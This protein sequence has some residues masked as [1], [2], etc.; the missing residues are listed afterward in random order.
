MTSTQTPTSIVVGAGVAGLTA[1]YRL[2]Q[3]GFRVTVLEAKHLPGGR[4]ADEMRGSFYAYTGA[5]GLFAFYRDMWSLLDELGIKDKLVSYPTMGQGIADNGEELYELDF[6]QTLGM[7]THRALSVRSRLRLAR[8][9]PDVM[10]ARL[11]VDPCLLHTATEFDDESMSEYLTRKVGLDFVEH[12]VGPVYRNLWAWNID[13][14]SRAYFLAIY[15]HVRGRPSYKLQTGLGLL[16]RT[17]ARQLDVRYGVRVRQIRRAGANLQR[18]VTYTSA[19]GDGQMHADIVVC[20][21]EG[22]RVSDLVSDQAPYERD[23]FGTVPYARYAMVHYVL[24]SIKKEYAIRTFFTRRHRNPISF[25]L[26]HQGDA[27]K[28]GDP[29]R[30]W[31]VLAPDRAPHYIGPAG[32]DFEPVMRKLVRE[33]YPLA[34]DDILET[35]EMIRDYTI[36]AFP[37]GQ[38]RRVKKFLASQESGPKNIYYVGDYLANATTGGACAIGHRTAQRII[39]DWRGEPAPARAVGS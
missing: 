36:A 38:L 15:A 5:T 9:I 23:F 13:D 10:A 6:N 29:P 3:A 27:T 31:A 33:R 18:T 25:I 35:H 19:D 20:A 7:L 39:A 34:D 14:I 22:N 12:V 37:P 21:V 4:M 1:A 28:P 16:T 2:K 11:R 30:L 17:L 24:K 32:E 8:L 26:T